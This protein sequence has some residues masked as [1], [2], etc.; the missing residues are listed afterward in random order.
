MNQSSL[1]KRLHR[2][3]CVSGC[4]VD[5]KGHRCGLQSSEKDETKYVNEDKTGGNMRIGYY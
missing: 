4:D 1:Q 3:T 2:N 5:T